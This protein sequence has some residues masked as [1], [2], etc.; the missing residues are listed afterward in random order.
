MLKDQRNFGLMVS[1]LSVG[2]GEGIR[3][4]ITIIDLT[5]FE[6]HWNCAAVP[7]RVS[8]IVGACDKHPTCC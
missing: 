6:K 8:M 3:S 1:T 7:I 2:L 4:C 5:C